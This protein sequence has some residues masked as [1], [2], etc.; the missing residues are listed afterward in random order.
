MTVPRGG[1]KAGAKPWQH[2]EIPLG[3]QVHGTSPALC[4]ACVMSSQKFVQTKDRLSNTEYIWA[5]C[6]RCQLG[7]QGPAGDAS[8]SQRRMKGLRGTVLHPSCSSKKHASSGQSL[9]GVFACGSNGLTVKGNDTHGCIFFSGAQLGM[10]LGKRMYWKV[11]AE[12][13]SDGGKAH[14]HTQA[15]PPP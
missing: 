11:L 9:E 4:M 15:G 5:M 6:S 8:C 14:R 13:V 3:S 12:N 7:K 10:S 1:G 2:L